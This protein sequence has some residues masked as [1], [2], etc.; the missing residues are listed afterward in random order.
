VEARAQAAAK[1][2]K[3]AAPKKKAGAKKA[4]KK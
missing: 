3:K 2:H 4:G 1:S